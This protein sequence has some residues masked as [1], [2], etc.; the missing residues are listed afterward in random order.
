MGD[1][2]SDGC[3]RM[4]GFLAQE[5]LSTAQYCGDCGD[6]GPQNRWL[7]G[8]YVKC[9]QMEAKRCLGV[10]VVD[11]GL[12]GVPPGVLASA[13]ECPGGPAA[14]EPTLRKTEEG[15][16]GRKRGRSSQLTRGAAG[17][18]WPTLITRT[19]QC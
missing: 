15:G 18:G 14:L 7:S 16:G 3:L 11:R 2:E 9:G 19:D 12:G 17:P 6:C 13:C 4:L 10:P 5:L 8:L 1:G